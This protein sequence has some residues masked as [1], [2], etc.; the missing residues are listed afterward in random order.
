MKK[1]SY[2]QYCYWKTN[3]EQECIPVGCVP[4]AAVAISPGGSA[5]VHAGITPP[6]PQSRPPGPGTLP[7]ADPLGPGTPLDQAPLLWTDTR[8]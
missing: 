1:G 7:G 8:L 5:S 2:A 3:Q 6:P 4:S